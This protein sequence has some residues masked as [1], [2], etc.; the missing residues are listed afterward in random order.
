MRFCPF[1]VLLFPCS[2][3]ILFLVNKPLTLHRIPTPKPGAKELLIRI[4]C[5]GLCHSD[6]ML[7]N[8]TYPF[9]LP[10]T[11]SHE[12]AGTVAAWGSEVTGWEVGERVLCPIASGHCGKCRHCK[13]EEAYQR[14]CFKAKQR[15][16]QLAGA[17]AE[18]MLVSLPRSSPCI[19]AFSH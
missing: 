7:M 5:A 9:P 16:V 10:L 13:G 11:V 19:D 14:Y 17:F 2:K 8:G 3:L 12:G 1:Q 15:G 4:V 6:H 18:Y